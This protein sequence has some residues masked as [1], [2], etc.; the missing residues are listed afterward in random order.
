MED[1]GIGA[2]GHANDLGHTVTGLAL[3]EAQARCNWCGTEMCQDSG[4]PDTEGCP[5]SSKLLF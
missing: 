4:F 5:E 2:L 1:A 3:A